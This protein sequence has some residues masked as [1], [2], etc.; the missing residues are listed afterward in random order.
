MLY[1]ILYSR[2]IIYM[3]TIV[4]FCAIILIHQTPPYLQQFLKYAGGPNG[5]KLS[6]GRE[7]CGKFCVF[8]ATCLEIAYIAEVRPCLSHKA[9]GFVGDIFT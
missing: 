8:Y 6:N 7:N 3:L 9:K 5:G 2:Y 4:Y 1:N